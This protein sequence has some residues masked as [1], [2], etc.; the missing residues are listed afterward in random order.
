VGFPNVDDL[1]SQGMI[2]D[3]LVGN[4][5]TAGQIKD[6]AG[7][8]WLRQRVRL[9]GGRSGLRG[10]SGHGAGTQQYQ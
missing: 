3:G 8:D 9:P 6:I 4:P 10:Y 1:N 7:D 2:N 5:E